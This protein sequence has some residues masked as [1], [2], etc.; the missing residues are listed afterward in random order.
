[1]PRHLQFLCF[2]SFAIILSSYPCSAQQS[3]ALQIV[4]QH[5]EKNYSSLALSRT[6]IKEIGIKSDYIDKSTGIRHIYAH[7]TL[8][9]LSVM[10]SDYSLHL[11]DNREMESNQL[12]HLERFKIDPLA[13]NITAASAINILMDHI[14]YPE[15]K[16]LQVKTNAT[17]K[18]QLTVFSRNESSIWDIPCRLVY[19]NNTRLKTLTPAW[20]VQMMDV[21]KQHYWVAYIDSRTGSILQK[22]DLIVRCDFGSPFL[23]DKNYGKK[24]LMVGEINEPGTQVLS[25][26]TSVNKQR[27]TGA[28]NKYRV[29]D[30]PFESPIDPGASH[31]LVTNTGDP[32]SSPDGWHKEANS[33]TYQYTRGNN[34]WAFQDPSPGPLGGV[35]S[36]DPTRTAYAN[37]GPLGTP[38]PE[39]PFYFDYPVD[40][41]SEPEDYMMGAIVNLF[42]WNNLMHDVFYY[43]GFTEDAG[44]FQSSPVFSTGTRSTSPTAL[45]PDEV[46]A[47]AQDGG[48]TNNANFLTLPDGTNGQMQ[49]YIWT[50][51]SPDFMVQIASSTT[52]TPTA[53]DKIFAV[54]GS[55][56][57][58][59][60]GATNLY[61]N[62]VLNK[63]FVI[64]EK[65]PLSI[66]GESSEGCSTG[67]QSVAL[68][69]GNNVVDKIVLIDRGDCS[70]AEK[71]LGAQLGGAAGVIVINNIPGPPLAMGGSDAP[72]N[73]I[74]IPAVMISKSDG[75][76]LKEQLR[77]GATIVG[78]LKRDV[79]PPPKRDGDIDNGVISHEY[80]H[81][82][83]TRLTGGPSSLGPLGGDEQG[84]EG[85]SDFVALYMTMRSND[86]QAPTTEHPN[87]ILPNR[88]I[89]NYVT[90]Q[91]YD[92]RGIREFPYSTDM[93]VNPATFGYIMRPD[94]SETHSVGFVWCSMLYELMQ[95][96]IDQYGMN[97]NVYE[98]ADPVGNNPP[99]SAKGNNIATRLVIEGMK[100]QPVSPTF[101]Q[102]RDA[103]LK[104]DTMLYNAQHAC[105][106]WKA[107][108]K[109]GL[110]ASAVSGSNVLGDE[111]EAFDVPFACDASQKRI[112]ISKSGPVMVKNQAGIEYQIT[113]AN[114]FPST[115]NVEVKDT[116]ASYLNFVSATNSPTVNGQIISWNLNLNPNDTIV[117]TVKAIVNTATTSTSLF[118]DDQENGS[119]NWTSSGLVGTPWEYSTDAS[120]AYSGDHYWFT[121][122]VDLGGSDVSLVLNN[123]VH[124]NAGTE[125][126]FLH[127]YISETN[128][129]GGVVEV[130]TD[131]TNWTY[132]PPSS[133]SEGNYSAI[134]ATADNPLIGTSDLPAFSGTSGGYIVSIASLNDYQGQD[135]FIR[136][137]FTCDAT[138][139]T[140]DNGGWWID[141]VY[142][143]QNRVEISN[144]VVGFTD[145]VS[146]ISRTEGINAYSESRAFVAGTQGPVPVTI[147]D[148]R[149]SAKDNKVTLQWKTEN[150]TNVSQ[151]I[152]ERKRT[153]ESQFVNAGSKK[154][155]GSNSSNEYS[156]DDYAVKPSETYVYR[157]KIVDKDGKISYSNLVSVRMPSGKVLSMNI[158]PN[159]STTV[160]NVAIENPA[161]GSVKVKIYNV[162]GAQIAELNGGSG[163]NINLS[164]PVQTMAAGTYWIEVKSEFESVT[165]R[166]VV[167][168]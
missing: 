99:P 50:A 106:I 166:L 59:P 147:S 21:K 83:S 78:S 73:G 159:P 167:G 110:G 45:L 129:D 116:L 86:L 56:N 14:Q 36:A 87:G 165:K 6:D 102:E 109:R 35:P 65:N 151:Y 118:S 40:L 5:L 134:I 115:T 157:L 27:L 91:N 68:P 111:I 123:A 19:Y 55:F 104:A 9:G 168:K 72:S 122:D 146:P 89:G 23:T 34:V 88:S 128:Y 155:M 141:D 92:G 67:Q 32:L 46:L 49:M 90:Y 20:E 71:V 139:G 130:S 17:G 30:M 98:G 39:E 4:K 162:S 138:G 137:R 161:G 114:V 62:P 60:V 136:F 26:N 164:L 154:A 48:G 133:F 117:I 132:L 107:F 13:V 64:V 61:T 127:K 1:M 52:G 69:P 10:G 163:K 160:A 148:L 77:D 144:S 103:I 42:Y 31:D 51:A 105:M 113:V 12:I 24:R 158:Y 57:T 93:N 2:L 22:R 112:Y 11:S 153:G 43:F 156:F 76:L 3:D 108:A 41:T 38:P 80:G 74:V 135:I 120:Q 131:G 100:Y 66:V 82:I 95:T 70:F 79:P 75:E 143:L 29:Y 121:P 16:T 85:W 54:Q 125:L 58:L 94:Y 37:N 145:Q 81:G 18:D 44:N 126:V 53:G 84:G 25:S 47:Q 28:A 7:Q 124:I 140:V 101:V 152:I 8:Q 149:G 150:E 142:I 96:F 63:E 97:D 15:S 33:I 119:G